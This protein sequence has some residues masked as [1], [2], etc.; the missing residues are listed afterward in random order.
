[1][2]DFSHIIKL[3]ESPWVLVVNSKSS[4][5]T[6]GELVAVARERPKDLNWGL[7]GADDFEFAH[8]L[9]VANIKIQGIRYGGSS[10]LIAALL[11]NEVQMIF[12]SIRTIQPFLVTGQLRAL[13][14]SSSKRFP[15][16]P[17]IP[18]IAE[19][20]IPQY[21]G[22]TIWFGVT[23]PAGMPAS[24]VDKLNTEFNIA[25]RSPDIR[26]KIEQTL[27]FEVVGGSSQD[28][29]LQLSNEIRKMKETANKAGIVPQ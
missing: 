27:G 20:G 3:V 5:K 13:A 16:A 18:T 28:F 26:Q 24:V 6:V 23:G 7:V 22:G 14:V 4:I 25:L 29:I 12:N 15:L 2:K 10:P 21:D 17:V 8:F 9:S 1:M 19:S 11:N